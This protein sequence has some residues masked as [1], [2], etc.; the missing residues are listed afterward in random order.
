MPRCAR[1]AKRRPST[2]LSFDWGFEFMETGP[3]NKG[4]ISRYYIA[5]SEE[6]QVSLPIN[7]D[8]GK[9]E[10]H[11]ARWVEF[12]KASSMVAPRLRPVVEWAHA[13]VNHEPPSDGR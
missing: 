3:Y 5:R 2:D 12:D 7:P 4:K 6:M 1:F 9:P 11:E 8:L 10:H 13:L